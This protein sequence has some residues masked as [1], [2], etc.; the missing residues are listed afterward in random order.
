[1]HDLSPTRITAKDRLDIRTENHTQLDGAVIASDSGNLKLDTG[2]LGFSDIAGKDREHGYYLNVGGSYGATTQ[3]KSQEGRGKAGEN[4][5]SVSGH[6]YQKDREQI[7]RATVG[8][9]E[10]LVRDV[11]PGTDATAGLNRDVAKAYEITRDDESRTDV[12]ASSSSLKAVARPG[13]TLNE[14]K[15]AAEAYGATSQEAIGKLADSFV[16]AYALAATG[17]AQLANI[18]VAYREVKRQLGGP[19]DNA[20]TALVH[21][22]IGRMTQGH[23]APEAQALSARIV[24]LAKENPQLAGEA[25]GL[26]LRM[27]ATSPG[28]SNFLPVLAAGAPIAALGAALLAGTQSDPA[29]VSQAANALMQAMNKLGGSL[30]DQLRQSADLWAVLVGTAFPI[31]GLDPKYGTLVTPVV[32]NDQVN[33]ASGGFGAGGRPLTPVSTGGSGIS[34][35]GGWSTTL[36]PVGTADGSLG[37]VFAGASGGAVELTFDRATRTWTTPAGLDYG[38]GSVQGNRVLHVLEHAEPNPAKT[39]HSVFSMDRKEILGTID[40]AWL[41]KGSPVLNDPGAYVV[42]MGRAIGT[43][44]ETSIKIIVR[45]GTSQVITAYPVK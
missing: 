31:H 44:G 27:H 6:D 30:Q 8:A 41:K 13:D 17:N 34:E 25:L 14:W 19:D 15:A 35:S 32:S 7:V 22:I 43:S 11:L 9:G 4:N 16:A 40:E 21:K 3:D 24:Q 39:T 42:P 38:Q 18:A 26:L 12:Y 10:V 33:G 37:L 20:R 23:D 36:P 1:M 28:V 5:W 45:P 2:T 29:L